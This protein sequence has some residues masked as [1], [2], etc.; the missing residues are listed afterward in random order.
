[1]LKTSDFLDMEKPALRKAFTAVKKKLDSCHK[2]LYIYDGDPDGVLSLL[3]MQKQFGEGKSFLAP[4]AVEEG[5]VEV[6]NGQDHDIIIIL[7]IASIAEEVFSA[8][9]GDIVW[10]DH[11]Q[12]ITYK[13]KNLIYFNPMSFSNG[14]NRC[15][16]FWAFLLSDCKYLWQGCCGMVSDWQFPPFA[17][18]FRKAY[19]KMLPEDI[20]GLPHAMF[21]S[22]IGLLGRIIG[23]N[24]KGDITSIKKSITA[25]AKIKEPSEIFDETTKPGRTIMKKYH[26]VQ[27]EYANSLELLKKAGDNDDPILIMEYR[28]HNFSYS[29]ELSNE[30]LFLFPHKKMII[31]ARRSSDRYRCSLRSNVDTHIDIPQLLD[32][33]FSRV[34]GS[35]GGHYHSCGCWVALDDFEEFS[36][37]MRAETKK[38]DP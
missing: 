7:D 28:E 16:T 3:I 24:L 29:S 32:I 31:I 17:D 1:M 13:K 35:G 21:E 12:A 6:V 37:I 33:A 14:D 9:K 34:H 22:Q 23:F 20:S 30:S 2:P 5:L 8:F 15:T 18:A 26:K 4:H 11:H 36:S 10:I 27:E 38:M 19:P 25:L